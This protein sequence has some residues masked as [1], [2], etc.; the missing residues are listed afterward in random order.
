MSLIGREAGLDDDQINGI[1]SITQFAG[2]AGALSISILTERVRHRWL[3]LAIYG[4]GIAGLFAF[5]LGLTYVTFLVLNA[6]F[7]FCWNAGQPLMLAI[8]ASRQS[9][10]QLLRFAIP[11]QFIGMGLAP[12][13]AATM[14]DIS[15]G[16][17]LV[18]IAS[19]LAAIGSFLAI[20]P[21]ILK[22]KRRQMDET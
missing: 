8:I 22:L 16:Y 7:Q 14:L 15:G 19:G 18:I 4:V 1:L 5:D 12:S 6:I 11:L 3:A 20:M 2:V 17:T 21:F 9:T 13:I 10:G